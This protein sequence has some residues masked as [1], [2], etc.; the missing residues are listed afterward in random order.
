MSELAAWT[1]GIGAIKLAGGLCAVWRP[2]LFIRGVRAF[3]RS[4]WPGRVLAAAALVWAAVM[5]NAMPMG[6]L[7]PYK[8]LLW[9]LCPVTIGLVW[10]YMDELLAPRALAGL[11][12]LVAAPLL[13]AARWHPSPWRL[14]MTV[15][16]YLSAIEGAAIMLSPWLFRRISEPACRT[17]GRARAAGVA[18]CAV[19]VAFLF[20]AWL[21]Y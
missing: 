4:L 9:I 8:K 7:E 6:S 11:L 12:M 21:V 19:G 5:L 13:D 15:I 2:D 16:A 3:P 17:P 20:L 1:A 14:I 10:V 18:A